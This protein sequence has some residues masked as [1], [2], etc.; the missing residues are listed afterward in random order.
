MGLENA[1][2]QAARDIK[3]TI[4]VV[5]PCVLF[6]FGAVCVRSSLQPHGMSTDQKWGT[7]GGGAGSVTVTVIV[8][9]SSEKIKVGNGNH[10]IDYEKIVLELQS[11]YR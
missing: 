1:S 2:F 11:R 10:I 6:V 3:P 7:L 4:D 5:E 9:I 8:I